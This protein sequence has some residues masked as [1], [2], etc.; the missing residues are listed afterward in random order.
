[1][2]HE[3]CLDGRRALTSGVDLV[4]S[5]RHEGSWWLNCATWLACCRGEMV[6]ARQP[7]SNEFPPLADAPGKY[8]LEK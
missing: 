8:V 5:E 2:R 6:G 3:R 4:A 1:L 7:G